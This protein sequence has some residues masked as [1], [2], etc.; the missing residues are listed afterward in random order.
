M[1]PFNAIGYLL[2][3]T[4]TTLL[5][6]A[7]HV[8]QEQLGIGM[9]QFKLLMML[10]RS[11]NM[12]QIQLATCLGQTEASISRQI[13]LLSEKGYI[14][15]TI[16]PQSRRQHVASITAEGEKVTKAAMKALAEY[17]EPMF[18]LLTPEQLEQFRATLILL[19]SH[20]CSDNK[21]FACDHPFNM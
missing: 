18:E 17:S 21:P 16:D 3:H 14:T 6:Q 19:H 20:I 4:A 2:Q 15:S 12:Q 1:Q 5:R 7:D 11:S 9:A 13:K 10:Q 8:L